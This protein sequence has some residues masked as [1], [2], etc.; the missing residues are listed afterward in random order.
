MS[1][2]TSELAKPSS[3]GS[4]KNESFQASYLDSIII[5]QSEE[6]IRKDKG[7]YRAEREKKKGMG[8]EESV[9]GLSLYI[10]RQGLGKKRRSK[11]WVVVV[12]EIILKRKID[13][14]KG[15]HMTHVIRII[16]L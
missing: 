8:S 2:L 3:I 7:K 9:L 11:W 15:L 13:F 12:V 16:C 6:I 5:F 14:H 1:W 4:K 10:Y